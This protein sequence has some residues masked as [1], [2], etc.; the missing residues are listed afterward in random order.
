MS[1]I[2]STSLLAIAGCIQEARSALEQEGSEQI[3][4]TINTVPAD[5][6]RHA[7]EIARML[8]EN[9]EEVGVNVTLEMQREDKHIEDILLNQDF[10]LYVDRSQPILEPDQLYPLLHS[11]FSSD[12]GWSNP[13]GFDDERID[14]LLEAQRVETG[15][16]RR[17][18]VNALLEA[19]VQAKPFATIGFPEEI[20]VI[21]T[22][23]FDGWSDSALLDPLDFLSIRPTEGRDSP[24]EQLRLATSDGRITKNL[25][26]IAINYRNRGTLTSLLYDSLGRRHDG[27]I[28]PWL[29][30]DWTL[31]ASEDGLD[32]DVELREGLTFHD[33][34]PITAADIEFTYRFLA[35]TSLGRMEVATPAPRFQGQ[36]SPIVDIEQRDVRQ[37][38]LSLEDISKEVARE[39][40]TVP[41]FP[42]HEWGPRTGE[43][44][45]A[46][47][48]IQSGVTEALVWDNLEPIGSG[49]LQFESVTKN[50]SIEFSRFDDHFLHREDTPSIPSELADGVLF[51][52]MDLT[53]VPSSGTAVEL[54]ETG[55]SDATLSAIDPSAVPEI[56]K[57]DDRKLL[58]TEA[59]SVYHVGF[60]TRRSDLSNAQF[61][62][63][64]ARMIDPNAIA[65]AV[66]DDYF[67]PGKVPLRNSQWVQFDLDDS[68]VDFDGSFIGSDG[69][70]D[71]E[72]ARDLFRD[73][74]Y[75]YDEGRLVR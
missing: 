29:A 57:D 10:H 48:T 25:N 71:V 7:V 50:E 74:G 35:D 19:I 1:A 56:G 18:T 14:D 53:V 44:E 67:E 37:V 41:I 26:P 17:E 13:F 64:L 51:E 47:V 75:S 40:L 68:T 63:I 42:A 61:R 28:I 72:T 55:E 32:L 5:R 15:S 22:D 38:S 54:V 12:P 2:G 33:G 62:R 3:K 60:N 46:G 9:L 59:Q 20:R 43:V 30:R 31:E 16:E 4:L 27:E 73:A 70:L 6:D 36:V 24:A 8:Q 66:F 34:S 21:R 49:V 65:S 45:I 11:K 52:E 69:E 58:V 39:V 23:R